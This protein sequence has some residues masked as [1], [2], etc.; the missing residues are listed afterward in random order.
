MKHNWELARTKIDGMLLRERV[1]IFA[2]AAFVVI[3]LTSSMLLNPILA[4]QKALSAQLAQQQEKIRSLQAQMQA[5]LQA[6]K[7]DENSP[8]RKRLAEFREKLKIQDD[9]L[10]SRSGRMVEPDKISNM[11][12]QI[13]GKNG[14]LQLVA[15][16]TL[17]VNPVAVQAANVAS[18]NNGQKQVFK[19]AV[20][21][22]LRGGYLDLLQYLTE[23]EKTQV[24]LYW[25]D[26]SLNV[27]KYPDSVLVL[28]LY[29]LSM[30]KI[31]LKV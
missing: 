4:R 7:D 17:P 16:E 13:L 11:L 22:T 19:H 3:S 6:K 24:Q 30:D 5:A 18:A 2:A 31:W 14:K 29:T 27:D 20:K 8:L 9:N 10:Q 23:V 1:M 12:E 25:G 15:L 21:V 28:T 26:V